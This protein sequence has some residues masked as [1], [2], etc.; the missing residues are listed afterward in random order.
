[1]KSSLLFVLTLMLFSQLLAEARQVRV[2]SEK[3]EF[4]GK[5]NTKQRKSLILQNDS[6]QTKEY[7][8]KFTQGNIGSS[9]SMK[10]CLDN[11]CFNPVKEPHR[12][13]IKLKPGEIFT[14]LYLEFDLGIIETRGTFDFHFFNAENTRDTF[15]I[16]SVYTVEAAGDDYF[17]HKDFELGGVSPNPTNRVA[18]LDY[19]IKNP[20]VN[21]RVVVTSFIGNPIYDF[22]LDPMQNSL[23]INV[24]GLNPGVY[25]YTIFVDNKNIVTKKLVVNK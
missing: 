6:D 2:L 25:L 3:I 4:I 1:M 19:K 15:V 18:Q 23:E 22:R 12:I 7:F 16:E 9:Q 21:A 10:V 20:A 14:D 17:S 13:R 5:V 24:T 11:S 8:L